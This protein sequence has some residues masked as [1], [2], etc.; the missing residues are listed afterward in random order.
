[1]DPGDDGQDESIMLSGSA[2]DALKEFYADRDARQKQFEDLKAH[3]ESDAA[4]QTSLTMD[5]FAENWNESQFWY[6]QDTA[7]KLAQ[8]LLHESN[9]NT[10][11]AVVSAPS[12]FV[13]LKNLLADSGKSEQE[14]PKIYLLE[15]DERFGVF[16]EFVFYDFHNPLKLP[17]NLK[18][19]VDHIIC[20][21]PFLSEDCQTKAAMT[22]RWLSRSWGGGSSVKDTANKISEISHSS[23]L[24]V[25]TGE[26]MEH[27][28]SKLYRP[29]GIATTTFEPVHAKGLSNE[30]YCFAN[31]ECNKWRWR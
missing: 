10:T 30:F 25:C 6:S 22:V 29:R 19:S 31:F 3:A 12:V 14:M 8:E 11:I 27:L 20:D 13:Q 2:L 26:R 16:P 21:P 9:G 4:G 1:M 23:R 24:I 15:F 28:V 5:A 17:P 7:T 18:G